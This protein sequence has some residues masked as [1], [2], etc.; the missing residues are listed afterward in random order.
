MCIIN[1]ESIIFI[2]Q[3]FKKKNIVEGRVVKKMLKQT[4]GGQ[5]FIYRYVFSIY[6]SS[7]LAVPDSILV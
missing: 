3:T 5:V 7:Y 6:R 4:V 2:K 1:V